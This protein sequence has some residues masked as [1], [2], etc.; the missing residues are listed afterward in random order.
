M[1]PLPR[2]RLDRPDTLADA[3]GCLADGAV[4][5]AGGT[6]LLPSMKHRLFEPARL[7]SL[8]GVA[9]LRS[10]TGADRGLAIGAGMT[11]RDVSRDE[12]VRRL[13]P[14]LADACR[15]VATPTIQAMGTLGGQV[16][17]DTRCVFYNQPAGWRASVGGCLKKD[18]AVCH[19]APKGQGCYA[20]HS[21]DTIPALWLYD[22]VIELA[23]TSGTRRVPLRDL[24]GEDGRTWL[25]VR[26]GELITSITLPAPTSSVV[27]RKVRT[28]AAIDYGA[29]LV[30]VG[31]SEQG[32]RAV[33]SAIGPRP[34]E[35]VAATPEA[36][37]EAAHASVHPLATH[38][39]PVPWRRAL[40][41]VEVLRAA[42]GTKTGLRVDAEGGATG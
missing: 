9:S 42:Q 33:I 36:L 40:V 39:H 10:V 6:D 31:R 12:R 38:L 30:A 14:A 3:L 34:V 22:A 11:L 26:P 21:A 1:L 37:A 2:F 7:V 32:L 28:R 24:Y 15:T 19:V 13:F 25:G 18:G 16:A 17:L 27:H 20:A 35:V 8:S 29:L 5:L 4:V 23:S 41:R